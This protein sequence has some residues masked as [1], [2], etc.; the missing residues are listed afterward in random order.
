M[1]FWIRAF[2]WSNLAGMGCCVLPDPGVLVCG[3]YDARI[4]ACAIPSQ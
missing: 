1:D 4:L 2:V 3:K